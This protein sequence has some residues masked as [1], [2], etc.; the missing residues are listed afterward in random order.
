MAIEPGILLGEDEVTEPEAED[1]A[2]DNGA[3]SE[4]GDPEDSTEWPFEVKLVELASLVVDDRY[5]RPVQERFVATMAEEF[6]ETLVG[7]IDVSDRADGT[8]A[9][10]DG[11]QRVSAMRILP[12]PKTACYAAV[13]EDMDL[14]DEAGFFYRKN[15]DRRAMKG[16]YGFRARLV[17]GDL[18]ATGIDDV[19][20]S[21]GFELGEKTDNVKVIGAIS[22]VE[23]AWGLH[24]NHR[25]EALSPALRTIAKTWPGR[26]D[27]LSAQ[28]IAA[29]ARFWGDYPDAAVNEMVLTRA[30][31]EIGSPG[32]WI[33]LGRERTKAGLTLYRAMASALV[34]TYNRVLPEGYDSLE[35][36]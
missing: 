17:A 12:T 33:G 2:P 7:C 25:S 10:L 19:V 30:L 36:R 32:N 23:T 20:R 31:E 3:R 35:P 1:L 18:D 24:S 6:D 27:S 34:W 16:F 15:K 21:E 9:I 4:E 22:T 11:Q 14:E 26:E 13:F 29:L 5:Q 28:V 8:H